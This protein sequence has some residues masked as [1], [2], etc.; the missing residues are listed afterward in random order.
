VRA[1][2]SPNA[3]MTDRL[4]A[5]CARRTRIRDGGGLTAELES[6]LVL[7][8]LLDA[9]AVA[10]GM[11]NRQQRLPSEGVRPADPRTQEGLLIVHRLAASGISVMWIH[12]DR[13]ATG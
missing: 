10:D 5:S 1:L 4:A 12:P 11:K 13:S 9:L 7:S 6:D 3:G 2:S 8:Y